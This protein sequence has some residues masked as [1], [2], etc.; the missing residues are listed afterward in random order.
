MAAHADGLALSATM[1]EPPEKT[2]CGSHISVALHAADGGETL[3]ASQ[4]R[5]PTG[6]RAATAAAH[7]AL[8]AGSEAD[9]E[10]HGSDSEA[11]QVVVPGAALRAFPA[12]VAA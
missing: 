11:A 8:H 3:V 12:E 2:G 5:L 6:G 9:L 7:I 10:I 1:A 4:D